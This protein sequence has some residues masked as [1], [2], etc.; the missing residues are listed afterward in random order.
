MLLEE[1][2][3]YAEV[4]LEIQ[5]KEVIAVIQNLP[6]EILLK[7]ASNNGW[8]I[9][10]CIAHLNSYAE[11]YLPH[12][13]RAISKSPEQA[14]PVA[15][16]HS[17]IGKYFINSMDP[18]RSKKKF[19]ALKRHRPAGISSPGNV[20]LDFIQ[21]LEN[22]LILLKKAK[23][24]NLGKNSVKTSISSWIKINPGDAI[25]FLLTH[26]RRHLEQAKRN[27]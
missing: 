3:T 5:L 27:L 26:N 4:Q 7:P 20:V 21:H 2:L 17:M 15:F 16:K 24:K 1:F 11:F 8:S 23:N 12:I 18:D 9:A 13:E 6:E 25:Q 14:E 10:E 19:R 22:M